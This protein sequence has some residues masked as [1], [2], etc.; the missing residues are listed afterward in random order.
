[1][2]LDLKRD[3]I[4]LV[5]LGFVF[6]VI[7]LVTRGYSSFLFIILRDRDSYDFYK[8]ILEL[9]NW[10]ISVT[11]IVSGFW[12]GRRVDLSKN[13]RKYL[14]GLLISWVI[15]AMFL[16]ILW[17]FTEDITQAVYQI[18]AT[19][20]MGG[21]NYLAPLFSGITLGWLI[22]ERPKIRTEWNHSVLRY[23][24]VYQGVVLLRSLV[25][26]YLAMVFM[27]S[28]RNTSAYSSYSFVLSLVLIPVN[29][30]YLWKMFVVGKEVELDQDYGSILFTLW[31]PQ[32]VVSVLISVTNMLIHQTAIVDLLINS[33]EDIIG[34]SIRVFGVPFAL[35]CLG[36]IHSRYMFVE[37]LE[38]IRETEN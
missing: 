5:L 19:S 1:M 31:V 30:W 18:A 8:R 2:S 9:F 17:F 34:V 11:V 38:R 15:S 32:V 23:V 13:Y 29:L 26:S 36:Y 28:G 3:K 33:V 22:K 14:N 24:V 21:Y 6:L 27:Y 10:I 20:A 12:F 4:L 37:K 16:G 7:L 35:L 25:A